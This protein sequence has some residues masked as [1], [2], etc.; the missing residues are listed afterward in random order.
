MGLQ[1]IK[2]IYDI[3]YS[4]SFLCCALLKHCSFRVQYV[5]KGPDR[6]TMAIECEC[7]GEGP[8]QQ[9]EIRQYIDSW[10]VSVSEAFAHIMGWP[11][12]KV[13]YLYFCVPLCLIT[14][15][16]DLGISLCKSITSPSRK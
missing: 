1:A 7:D 5:Y 13:P 10:Y 8:V 15:F 3:C 16:S 11:M 2:Y 4:I 6:A 9:D 12:H 14:S